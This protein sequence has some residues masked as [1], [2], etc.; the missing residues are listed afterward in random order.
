M[1]L[2]SH[3]KALNNQNKQLKRVPNGWKIQF[4]NGQQYIGISAERS[5]ART[6]ISINNWRIDADKSSSWRHRVR[7][8]RNET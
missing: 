4:Q 2:D 1:W 8:N 6:P 5:I 3:I 7:W